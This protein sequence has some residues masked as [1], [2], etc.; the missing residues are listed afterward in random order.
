MSKHSHQGSHLFPT[1]SMHSWLID[2]MGGMQG[3]IKARQANYKYQEGPL[4]NLW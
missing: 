3:Q 1:K 4:T 2:D